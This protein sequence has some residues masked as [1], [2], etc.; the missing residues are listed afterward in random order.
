MERENLLAVSGLSVHEVRLNLVAERSK[1]MIIGSQN[2]KSC[3][4]IVGSNSCNAATINAFHAT[5]LLVCSDTT[6]RYHALT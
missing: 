3:E 4:P 1:T 5:K 2:V 6:G